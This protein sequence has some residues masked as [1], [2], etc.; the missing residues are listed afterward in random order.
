[1]S[2][3]MPFSHKPCQAGVAVISMRSPSVKVDYAVLN[4][5]I[6]RKWLLTCFTLFLLRNRA[7]TA[8]IKP[9]QKKRVHVLGQAACVRVGFS[10]ESVPE[11][12]PAHLQKLTTDNVM[13]QTLVTLCLQPS[14]TISSRRGRLLSHNW[15]SSWCVHKAPDKTR[16]HS[17]LK[18][19]L[20]L[21]EDLGP[22]QVADKGSVGPP[23]ASYCLNKCC[24]KKSW[25][26]CYKQCQPGS[27]LLLSWLLPKHMLLLFASSA[28]YATVLVGRRLSQKLY[29]HMA[30]LHLCPRAG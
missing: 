3:A 30:P 27:W 23:K 18:E 8:C 1:M 26:C 22:A 13:D 17:T 21:L 25:C 14:R 4:T 7:R 2:L 6:A 29:C 20:L 5:L 9:G 10:Q 28:G 15:R 12:C 19:H 11:K 24:S 16:S